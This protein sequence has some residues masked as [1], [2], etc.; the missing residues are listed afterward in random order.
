MIKVSKF[1][2]KTIFLIFFML[3]AEAES[4]ILSIGNPEAKVTI[5]VFSS[6]TCPHC[7]SFHKNIY[8]VLKVEYIDKGFVKFEHHAFPLDLAALNAE[9]IVRCQSNNEK[10]FELLTEIYKKQT[11]WAVGSDINKINE[12][13]KKIGLN[14]DLNNEI[15]NECLKNDKTQDEIL[16]QRIEA[17]KKYKIESTPTVFINEKKYSGKIDY[18]Q[19]KKAIEK[20]L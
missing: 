19:F 1:F 7:A 3:S 20:K 12:L 10:R 11:T 17:Q 16:E 2:Y 4:K 9:I 13:I 6:L 14:F 18:K 15:M 8:E 5:K